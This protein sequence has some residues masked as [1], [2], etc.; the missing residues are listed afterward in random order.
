M[1]ILH[2]LSSSE[3]S[4]CRFEGSEMIW[5]HILGEM[6]AGNE[7][8]TRAHLLG[9]I[10]VVLKGEGILLWY[11]WKGQEWRSR[12]R[13]KQCWPFPKV[14]VLSWKNEFP[15]RDVQAQIRSRVQAYLVLWYFALLCFVDI[16]LLWQPFF[17]TVHVT[18]SIFSR[19]LWLRHYVIFLSLSLT[20]ETN[21]LKS[22]NGFLGLV[23]SEV[24][25]HDHL[26]L[27]VYMAAQYTST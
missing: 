4:N 8:W 19:I 15:S 12:T 13:Q 22:R 3:F 6:T 27:F 14:D 9:T 23:I 18:V 17:S 5:N 10:I 25:I 2:S 20:P 24:A 7:S 21:Q 1:R 11:I 26:T 16:V